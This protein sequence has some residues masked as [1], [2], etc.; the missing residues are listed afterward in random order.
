MGGPAT[1]GAAWIPDFLT[2][3][4]K[5]HAPIDFVTTHT[6]GVKGGFVDPDGKSDL[7]LDSSP[8]AIVGD[9]RRVH[10]Q[11]AASPFPDLPLYITEWSTSYTPADPVHD[12]YISAAYILSKLKA[13]EGLAQGMSYWTYSDLFEESGPPPAAF[14]GG[15]G[16]VTRDGIRKPAFFAYKYLHAL[17][18]ETIASSDTQSM[19]STN[20]EN[21]TAVLWDFQ[22]P[23]QKQGDR[24]FY[25]KLLP[26]HSAA[27]VELQVTHL[28]PGTTY[29]LEVHR[30]GCDAND[31]YSAY[32]RMGAPKDLDQSQIAHLD[33]LTRDQPE[34]DQT[35]R[36][37]PDGTITVKVPMR[38]NGIVLVTLEPVY[39][40]DRK[41]EH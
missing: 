15:F 6:Y 31:A 9:V 41:P 36:V 17:G 30:T 11:I 4:K 19:L 33:Y 14:Y 34:R 29:R 40:S 10:A 18:G 24:E 35:D 25:T 26:D 21:L 27:P 23:A 38:T 22:T 37:G 1:A 32:L 13:T 39:A 20:G 8:D 16:L 12:S 5:T 7:L 2:Y 28:V 3:V